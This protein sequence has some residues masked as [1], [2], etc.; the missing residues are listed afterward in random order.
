[1]WFI[2]LPEALQSKP[3]KEQPGLDECLSR[4]LPMEA[5]EGTAGRQQLPW[6][7]GLGRRMWLT[8]ARGLL[9]PY[10][11]A[12]IRLPAV[13]RHHPERPKGRLLFPD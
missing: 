5:I 13:A 12:S 2:L 6:S 11:Q 10:V 8:L 7:L 9:V 3:S 4:T 1:M